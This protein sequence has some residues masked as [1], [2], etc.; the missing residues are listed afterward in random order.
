[1]AHADPPIDVFWIDAE[2]GDW[3]DPLR[4]STQTFYPQNGPLPEESYRAIIDAAGQPY[5]VLMEHPFGWYALTELVL[6]SPDLTFQHARGLL[7][8]DTVNLMAGTYWFGGT[9]WRGTLEDA[10]VTVG[11]GAR[12][13]FS[14]YDG[15]PRQPTGGFRRCTILAD[16]H[17]DVNNSGVLF[18]DSVEL[19]GDIYLEAPGSAVVFTGQGFTLNASTISAQPYST[20]EVSTG[21]LPF[22]LG[23]D[24]TIT[25]A[26]V[27]KARTGTQTF[28]NEGQIL[29]PA[30]GLFEDLD[31]V[32]AG[33]ISAEAGRTKFDGS[34]AVF[35]N[36]GELI[37]GPG[38]E[39]WLNIP[40]IG[41]NDGLIVLSPG[42]KFRTLDPFILGPGSRIETAI[43]PAAGVGFLRFE[44]AWP[45]SV[46]GGALAIS[47][48][49]PS[50][51]A[52]GDQFLLVDCRSIVTRFASLEAPPPPA[53]PLKWRLRY[54]SAGVTIVVSCDADFNIDGAVDV[55]DVL[56]F[57]DAWADDD[58][59]ADW[60]GD[61]AVDTLD[62]LGFLNAWGAGC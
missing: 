45:R 33:L 39:F 31:F 38:A 27:V 50:A 56:E 22:V 35:T 18:E 26:A 41:R 53:E 20:I 23:P 19:F 24:A 5:T 59:A 2:S 43:D 47:V 17:L 10:V 62:F 3:E 11:P 13:G 58:P 46:L 7:H 9:G 30:G 49:D 52:L 14:G 55:L 57:L 51:F 32:N 1:M 29:L 34:E 25:G 48:D 61:G 37:I 15:Y 12:F 8:V 54:D 42:A 36:N 6:D 21:G 44:A 60:N 40:S 4:W 28:H 16:L